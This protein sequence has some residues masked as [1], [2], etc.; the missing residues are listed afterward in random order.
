[1][2]FLGDLFCG[3]VTFV[4]RIIGK[5]ASVISQRKRKR[6]FFIDL[7]INPSDI[8]TTTIGIVGLTIGS[9]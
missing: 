5:Y 6:S 2:Y 7:K 1:L 8:P 9:D 3:D 4:Q